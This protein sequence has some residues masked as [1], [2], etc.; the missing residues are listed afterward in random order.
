LLYALSLAQY[1]L[2]IVYIEAMYL[3]QQSS[4]DC[5]RTNVAVVNNYQDKAVCGYIVFCFRFM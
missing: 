5:L 3:F 2:Y 4:F 1:L